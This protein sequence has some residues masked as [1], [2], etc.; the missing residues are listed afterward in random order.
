MPK[1]LDRRWKE[2][3]DFYARF[4]DGPVG[5]TRPERKAE[6][7]TPPREEPSLRV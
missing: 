3:A 6:E 4:G 5:F 1:K 7:Q 2:E